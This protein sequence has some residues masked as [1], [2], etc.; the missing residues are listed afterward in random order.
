MPNAIPVAVN[1][2]SRSI[3]GA[4]DPHKFARRNRHTRC[5]AVRVL[6][7]GFVYLTTAAT[8]T[9]AQ[10][11]LSITTSYSGFDARATPSFLPPPPVSS[12]GSITPARPKTFQISVQNHGSGDVNDA[13]VEL[14]AGSSVSPGIGASPSAGCNLTPTP[15]LDAARWTIGHLPAGAQRECT[16]TLFPAPAEF[17]RGGVIRA[18]VGANGNL[19]PRPNN[20]A[21]TPYDVL[22]S[23]V[24]YVRDMA[25][26]IRSPQGILRPGIAYPIDFVLTNRGPGLEG[27]PNF[28]QS[29]Y[30]ERYGV[31]PAAGE[32]FALAYDGD[33][34]C[35]YFV[36]DVGAVVISRISEI[37]FG[38]LAPGQSRTCTM[39]VAV[40]PGATGA[41]RLLFWNFAELPGVFDER[42]DN[43]IADLNLLYSAPSIPAGSRWTWLIMAVALAGIGLAHARRH[44]WIRNGE[45]AD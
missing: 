44:R 28:T 7:A 43:N 15:P 11:D 38:P 26:E 33:P 40:F 41:R 17:P 13:F 29:I 35:R 3:R 42:L 36:T 34:D 25:L 20:D 2:L 37:Q 8:P 10:S 31:G 16:L 21:G 24:D 39:L 32:F 45:A 12:G 4:Y 19:D 5:V 18:R 1:S 30:S 6:L 27:N 22:V 23:P 14:F 9:S